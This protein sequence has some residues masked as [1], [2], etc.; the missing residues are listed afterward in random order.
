MNELKIFENP[1]FGSVRTVLKDNE[2]WFVSSDVCKVLGLEQVSRAMDRIDPDERGLLEVTHPQSEGKTMLVN[3]VN[4]YGLYALVLAST[5]DE[6]KAFKR[7]ITHE[8]IPDIRRHGMYATADTVDKL[9]N[10]P[11]TAIKMLQQYKEEK[12]KRVALEAQAEQDKPKVLFA[13]S[14]A[15]SRHSILIG[16]LAKLLKQ[17]GIQIGQN[18]LFQDL[19]NDGYLCKGGERYNLPTQRSMEAG[20]FD[21]KETTINRPDGAVMVTRTTKVTGRGQIYFIN[22]YLGQKEA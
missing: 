14:V 3:G 18:R 5:K 2:P 10:D 22:R 6:A 21:L 4:E 9:L 12:A 16:E 19:R 11:D 15:A 1:A 17:N 8:V 20:W 7:W 13:D